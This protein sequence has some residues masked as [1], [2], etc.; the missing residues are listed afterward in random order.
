MFGSSFSRGTG[1]L[2]I[3]KIKENIDSPSPEEL[4]N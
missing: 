1:K 2:K 3:V 4:E